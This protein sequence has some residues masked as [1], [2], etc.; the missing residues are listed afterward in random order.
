MRAWINHF[1]LNVGVALSAVVDL[2]IALFYAVVPPQWTGHTTENISHLSKGG[3]LSWFL[4]GLRDTAE[5]D[6]VSQ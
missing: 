5:S 2:A 3:V 1:A 4:F 6:E